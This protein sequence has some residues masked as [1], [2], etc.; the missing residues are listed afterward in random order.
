MPLCWHRD[1]SQIDPRAAERMIRA[2]YTDEPID[3]LDS[4]T[5]GR[6]QIIL[7]A[8]L[9][10]SERLGDAGLDA[11]LADASKLANQWLAAI[12]VMTV[13]V[14]GEHVAALRAFLTGDDAF[15][16]VGALL[17]GDDSWQAYAALAEA[18]FGV[19]ARRRFPGGYK[20]GD[21][22]RFVGRT[23]AACRDGTGQIHPGTAER[24]PSGVLSDPAGGIATG[25]PPRPAAGCGRARRGTSAMRPAC[26]CRSSRG[27]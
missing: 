11:F 17:D 5:K 21:V 10:N 16:R 12:S 14:G 27:R 23:R 2:V 1:G 13:P 3:D 9:V 25:C 19:A 15:G 24:L 8:A 20:T 4:A 22:I 6:T 7:L 18:A 26:A